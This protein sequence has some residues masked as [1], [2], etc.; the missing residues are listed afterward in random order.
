MTF[1]HIAENISRQL[2][3]CST[4]GVSSNRLFHV[5]PTKVNK[6]EIV[7]VCVCVCVIVLLYISP[8]SLDNF[9]TLICPVFFFF[10]F[11]FS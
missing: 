5:G 11:F 1:T 10:F 2:S 7:C 6:L 8:L 3:R 9:V 4:A